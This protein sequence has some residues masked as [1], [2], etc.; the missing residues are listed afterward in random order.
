MYKLT[1]SVYQWA[2]Y[3]DRNFHSST[4][5][6]L[7]TVHVYYVLMIAMVLHFLTT[8]SISLNIE[9]VLKL[10][11]QLSKRTRTH[12]ELN[13]MLMH[14]FNL[15]WFKCFLPF[16]LNEFSLLK[17]RFNGTS[18]PLLSPDQEKLLLTMKIYYINTLCCN[19]SCKMCNKNQREVYQP[20]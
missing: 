5:I 4:S 17:K 13:N 14:V 18:K 2:E 9:M 1:A 7:S 19:T 15:N 10:M 16:I 11:I 12:I 8:R 3:I 20:D 6:V